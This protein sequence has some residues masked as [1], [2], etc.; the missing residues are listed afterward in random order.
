MET[1][2]RFSLPVKVDTV[3]LYTLEMPEGAKVLINETLLQTARTG[4]KEIVLSVSADSQVEKKVRYHFGTTPDGDAKYDG[5]YL[6]AYL[7]QGDHVL[8]LWFMW[9]LPQTEVGK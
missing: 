1:L 6:G 7:L 4:F 2:M 9:E 5:E 3:A 8:H